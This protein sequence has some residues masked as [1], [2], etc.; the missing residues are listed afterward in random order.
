M[1]AA[2]IKKAI[3]GDPIKISIRQSLSCDIVHGHINDKP[4]E[5]KKNYKTICN[6]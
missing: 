2:H 5:I 1:F 6:A 4:F 3:L